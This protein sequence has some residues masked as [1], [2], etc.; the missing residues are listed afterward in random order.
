MDHTSPST[1]IPDTINAATTTLPTPVDVTSPPIPPPATRHTPT[2]TP[3]HWQNP[4]FCTYHQR[5]GHAAHNCHS[6]ARQRPPRYR[7][8]NDTQLKA[9]QQYTSTLQHRH[10]QAPPHVIRNTSANLATVPLTPA[11]QQAIK[12]AQTPHPTACTLLWVVDLESG[13][14]I[15][16][17]SGPE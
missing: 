6:V 4:D 8:L 14:D 7:L 12:P 2:I 9:T 10:P 5:F 1:A 17:D 13:D 3:Q 11:L 15:L 16:V